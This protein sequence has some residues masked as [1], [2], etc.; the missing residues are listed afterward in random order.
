MP[1]HQ[2]E[3]DEDVMPNMPNTILDPGAMYLE[4]LKSCPKE[5]SEANAKASLAHDK[6]QADLEK[7]TSERDNFKR[8]VKQVAEIASECIQ[9]EEELQVQLRNIT[10][11]LDT[12]KQE[13]EESKEVAVE[14]DM[15]QLQRDTLKEDLE[16]A[17][18]TIESIQTEW[19][20][21]YT[22]RCQEFQK[23]K[24]KLD[25]AV[26][27]KDALQYRVC[28][29]EKEVRPSFSGTD[30]RPLIE[31]AKVTRERD[32]L[33]KRVL[34]LEAE[35]EKQ[36]TS[37]PDVRHWGSQTDA[38]CQRTQETQTFTV[39]AESQTRTYSKFTDYIMVLDAVACALAVAVILLIAFAE[40]IFSD[41]SLKLLRND[42]P[43]HYILCHKDPFVSVILLL[44]VGAGRFSKY[45]RYGV[46]IGLCP[47]LLRTAVNT[48]AEP[49]IFWKGV[50]HFL[51]FFL[52]D[53]FQV[54][55][56][57]KYLSF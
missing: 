40:S 31:V 6:L 35:L 44:C 33:Q 8:E 3:F 2:D 52:K 49:E 27:A 22:N 11:E 9:E 38:L 43:V 7:A 42:G 30:P 4:F 12:L 55:S 15:L 1:Q 48:I 21:I 50:R 17:K 29:L 28:T 36:K 25:A 56:Q 47:L 57:V 18:S 37:A 13:L 41:D 20:E 34:T 19:A 32:S 46:A 45:A 26:A 5:V 24:S 10:R 39:P 23:L 54:T 51:L 53:V 14:R 16:K